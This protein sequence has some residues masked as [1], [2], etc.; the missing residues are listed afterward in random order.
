MAAALRAPLLALLLLLAALLLL[1]ALA[2][3]AALVAL[4]VSGGL[5]HVAVG[6]ELRRVRPAVDVGGVVVAA[7]AGAGLLA[8]PRHAVE[9]VGEL[10]VVALLH[11]AVGLVDDEEGERLEAREVRVP[12]RHEVPQAPRRRDDD[13]RALRQQA[14]LLD[15]RD[16]ADDR[17]DADAG[18][19]AERLQVAADLQRELA[20]RCED[21]RAQRAVDVHAAVRRTAAAAAIRSTAAAITTTAASRCLL[22]LARLALLQQQL[23]DRQPKR[24]RLAAARLRRADNVAAVA[25]DERH[26]GGLHGSRR[27]KALQCERALEERVQAERQ[28]RAHVALRRRRQR[29]LPQLL[30]RRRHAGRG[31][32]LFP[33]GRLGRL[34]GGLA[35]LGALLALGLFLLE[36]EAALLARSLGG[37][38]LL[39]LVAIV[40]AAALAA[41]AAAAVCCCSTRRLLALLALLLALE[42]AVLVLERLQARL[43]RRDV[44][45]GAAAILSRRRLAALALSARLSRRLLLLLLL[46]SFLAGRGGGGGAV[47]IAVD[48]GAEVGGAAAVANKD[49]RVLQNL[50]ARKAALGAAEQE[51]VADVDGRPALHARPKVGGAG[52]RRRALA[53]FLL[54]GASASC[55]RGRRR[56]SGSCLGA[57]ISAARCRLLLLLPVVVVGKQGGGGRARV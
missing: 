9:D 14:L 3:L 33:L 22:R 10:L 13:G 11:H 1:L 7:A 42:A 46:L 17:R 29:L 6:V 55:G 8:R 31:A 24:Q 28:P 49:R 30:Q 20:R 56:G 45:V 12:L 36:L 23:Q 53:L 21:Q 25:R 50:E 54:G 18:D 5:D 43:Q 52:R 19:A 40:T 34:G 32:G 26:R 4:A 51:V 57:A 38:V 2:A 41:A 15:G 47:S 16:A 37:L 35:L 27:V 39:L 48:G 44:V